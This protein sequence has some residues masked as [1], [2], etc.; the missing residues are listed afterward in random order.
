MK[1]RYLAML[2]A[3]CMVFGMAGCSSGGSGEEVSNEEG[4]QITLEF[5]DGTTEEQYQAWETEMIEAFEE[6]N[7]N[8]KIEVQKVSAD[9]FNQTVMTRFASG[10]APDILTFTENDITDIV[11]SGY[12]M[13]LSDSANIENYDEGMLDSLS[14]DG[15]VYALPIANDFMCVTYSKDVFEA[16]GITEVP[17]TWDEFI[18]Y[19]KDHPGQVRVGDQGIGSRVYLLVT[20]VEQYYGVQFNKI[21]Y[22]SS[23][24]QRE[25]LLNGEVDCIVSS[26]GDFAPIIQSGDAIGILEFSEVRNPTYPD[27]PTAKE[28]GLPDE[29]ISGSFIIIAGPKGLSEEVK[30]KLVDAFREA[31]NSQ[32]FADWA[33]TVGITPSWM[34]GDELL[35]YCNQLK[36]NDFAALDVLKEQGLI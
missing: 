34:E 16:A 7:P 6:E 3:G 22:T 14:L 21:S 35:E 26:L 9:S 8:I 1:K 28:I 31:A 24:P 11:P 19:A 12:I 36:V 4:E 23:A 5:L 33:A 17:K 2:L 30:T 15:K 20:K 32:E 10:D 13:D 27:V 25:A 18:Q 29:F